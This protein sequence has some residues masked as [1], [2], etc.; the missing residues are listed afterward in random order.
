[1]IAVECDS[2]CKS[3]GAKSGPLCAFFFKVSKDHSEAAETQC[4]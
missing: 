3:A 1:M 4:L 2:H